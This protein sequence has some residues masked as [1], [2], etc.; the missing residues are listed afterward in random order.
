MKKNTISGMKSFIT[1]IKMFS[2]TF[3]EKVDTIVNDFKKTLLNCE[4]LTDCQ[5]VFFRKVQMWISTS[6]SELPIFYKQGVAR[7]NTV[8]WVLANTGNT[9]TIN[10]PILRGESDCRIR[11]FWYT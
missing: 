7:I 9:S 3:N 10:L 4:I 11:R 8:V 5:V 2:L 1:A 6:H